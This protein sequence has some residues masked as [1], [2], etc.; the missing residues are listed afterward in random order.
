MEKFNECMFKLKI[1]LNKKIV[2]NEIFHNFD[3]W[4]VFRI[5]NE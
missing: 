4:N 1:S 3:K 2:Q 5:V